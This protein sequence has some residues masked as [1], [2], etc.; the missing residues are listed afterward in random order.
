METIYI[1]MMFK[2]I[3]LSGMAIQSQLNFITKW[4]LH[5]G[6]NQ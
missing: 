3:N 4:S 6:S 1:S 2:T 5:E